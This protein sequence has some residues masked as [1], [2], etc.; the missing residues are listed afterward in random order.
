[1]TDIMGGGG[2]GGE[3][4]RIVNVPYLWMLRGRPLSLGDGKWDSSILG[5]F[6]AVSNCLLS[7]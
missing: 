7:S 1:M 3:G 5:A 6:L 2:E 4:E